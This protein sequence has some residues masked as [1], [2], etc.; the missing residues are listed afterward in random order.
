LVD[1]EKRRQLGRFALRIAEPGHV[2]GAFAV[3]RGRL[4][5]A[6]TTVLFAIYIAVTATLFIAQHDHVR[7][8]RV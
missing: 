8:H 6:Q 7:L 5:L 2:A 1:V 4:K 3:R